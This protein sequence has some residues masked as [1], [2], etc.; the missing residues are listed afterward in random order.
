MHLDDSG[1]D[2]QLARQQSTEEVTI[3]RMSQGQDPSIPVPA[4]I[5]HNCL[6]QATMGGEVLPGVEAEFKV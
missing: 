5:D 1:G 3:E 4:A 6:A 2:G